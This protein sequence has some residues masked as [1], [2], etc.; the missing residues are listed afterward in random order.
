[1]PAVPERQT[2]SVVD[3]AKAVVTLAAVAALAIAA[4][5]PVEVS[6]DGA[7]YRVPVGAVVN[8]LVRSGALTA[9]AGDLRS[10]KG[11][12]LRPGAGQPAQ[13]FV[14]GSPAVTSTPVS[15]GS[16]VTS[17]KGDDSVESTKTV[18]RW[19]DPKTKTVG[20]GPA[21]SVVETGTPA[22]LLVVVGSESGIEISSTVIDK[23]SPLLIKRERADGS[24]KRVALTFDDGPWP[25]TT[26]AVLRLLRKHKAKATF[27]VVGRQVPGRKRIVERLVGAG[28][29][30]GNHSYS[31]KYL[32]AASDSLAHS[33][34]AKADDA[35]AKVTGAAPL[36]YRP[37]GG[38]TSP[39]VFS[40]A[41]ADRHRL[42]LWTVDPADWKRPGARRIASRVLSNV[43]PGAVILLHD[44]GG[45]R[46]QTV[47]ALKR[48]LRGLKKRGYQAVTLSELYGVPAQ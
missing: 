22:E 20:S 38:S 40:E 6:A 2:L 23:G 34:I 39:A 5:S 28:M 14:N 25:K 29:E 11:K 8:D 26:E 32:S 15:A 41:Y 9:P 21:M 35:I 13:F 48:I 27:F 4:L 31:H 47:S 36:W 33:E 45:D 19:R 42:A 44:G 16:V 17:S 43:H 18:T 37:A 12:V 3:I 30:I 10:V 46:R 7:K 1:M 24:A